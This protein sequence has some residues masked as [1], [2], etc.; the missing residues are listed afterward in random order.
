MSS[1]RS[2]SA[3]LSM[4]TSSA[5]TEKTSTKLA[6]TIEVP[7]RE[8]QTQDGVT[9]GSLNKVRLF[10]RPNPEYHRLEGIFHPPQAI[11]SF[12]MSDGRGPD[13]ETNPKFSKNWIPL[14]NS[15]RN[16]R[17]D[18]IVPFKLTDLIVPRDS[19]EKETYNPSN[20]ERRMWKSLES[21]HRSFSGLSQYTS[22]QFETSP[23]EAVSKSE[24]GGLPTVTVT[25][26]H[27]GQGEVV[28]GHYTPTLAVWFNPHG[29]AGGF[30]TD[31]EKLSSGDI[32][33]TGPMYYLI[34]ENQGGV[35]PLSHNFG[36]FAGDRSTSHKI[37]SPQP[38][39]EG[40]EAAFEGLVDLE[41]DGKPCF[42]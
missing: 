5:G 8:S 33:W 31:S 32:S 42:L 25:V 1:L 20:F 18:V 7:S 40:T 34:N 26:L 15:H 37:E 23:S 16:N 2:I 11:Y 9:F 21:V 28:G 22:R 35:V 39:D 10:T 27:L 13:P 36:K 3:R 24:D 14:V 29:S 17:K 41:V 12:S 38:E 19:E 4:L 30:M 6:D